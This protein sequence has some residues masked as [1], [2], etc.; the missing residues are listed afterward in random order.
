MDLKVEVEGGMKSTIERSPSGG[1]KM[2][3][4]N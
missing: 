1:V 2:P 4:D 3:F